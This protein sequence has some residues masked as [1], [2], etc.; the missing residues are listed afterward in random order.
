MRRLALIF[1]LLLLP[2]VTCAAP[3]WETAPGGTA[4]SVGANDRLMIE[5]GGA[6]KITTKATLLQGYLTGNQNITVSGDASGS[7]ATGIT[8]TIG[9]NRV[10]ERHLKAVNSP[11]DEYCLTYEATTGDFEWQQCGGITSLNGSNLASQSFAAGANM[12]IATADG[13]HT[14][15]VT[16]VVTSESDPTVAG[17]ISAHLSAADHSDN[18][19]ASDVP[20][21]D[22]GAYYTTDTV[23]AALQQ[24]GP[25]MTNSRTPTT[26]GNEA[27]SATYLTSE[28]D[29]GVATHESTYSHSL[30]HSPVTAGTGISVDGQQV[31]N[32]DTGSA[33]VASHLSAF[34]H[35][36]ISHTNRAALDL[37]SGTNTGDQD[38]SG[39]A[40]L[41]LPAEADPVFT[42]WDKSTGISIT[43]SQI[44]DLG[45]YLTAETDPSVAGAIGAHT[46]AVQHGTTAQEKTNITTAVNHAG[47]A[48]ATVQPGADGKRYIW[49]NGAYV[50]FDMAEKVRMELAENPRAVFW[51]YGPSVA[52]T[53]ADGDT[54]NSNDGTLT[55]YNELVG[56][57]TAAGGTD[58]NVRWLCDEVVTLPNPSFQAPLA[59]SR[60][61]GRLGR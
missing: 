59:T 56:Y 57:A 54:P 24:I 48:H 19:T 5:Q 52:G 9:D 49:K 22:T 47:S 36:D 34:T 39:Y 33:A 60:F 51:V 25:T 14:F 30:L 27:H 53:C 35:G 44:S 29:P 10:L 17:A 1:A 46:S 40:T 42:A 32:T 37:V 50:P 6:S 18:Q 28:S 61:T 41:P 3:W 43:E 7:G 21:T 15:A 31:S 58:S 23:E 26:H 20:I 45:T 55:E 11:T 13:V 4:S 38:L 2:S 16:G 8:L 12:S